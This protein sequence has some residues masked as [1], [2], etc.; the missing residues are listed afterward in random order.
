M[1]T[2]ELKRQ[3]VESA[4]VRYWSAGRFAYHF[5]KGKLAG[6]PVFTEILARALIPARARVLDLGCGQG[7]LAAWLLAAEECRRS[8]AWCTE[9]PEPPSDW[10]F[11]GIELMPKDVNR[12]R[13]ALGARV[14]V[15]LG[16]IR[17]AIL[18][19]AD[20]V[21]ILDVLHYMN[22][23]SQ[24]AVLKRVRA[25]LSHSG[26]LLLRIGDAGA[27]LR[28]RLSQW[29]DQTVLMVRGHGWVRLHCRSVRAWTELLT[30]LGFATNVL[31]MSGNTPFANVLLVARAQ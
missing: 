19:A 3:M 12:A 31:S 30:R 20:V 13:N 15:E 1:G 4:A 9:W 26:T 8:R 22:A 29:V 14:T 10:T 7:L 28:F 24:E 23:E 5:A 18:V 21:L 6:D 25:A 11:H 27:G 2:K 16:D 17:S